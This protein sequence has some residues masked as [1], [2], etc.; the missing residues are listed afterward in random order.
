MRSIVKVERQYGKTGRWHEIGR[1]VFD[2]YGALPFKRPVSFV[3]RV[4]GGGYPRTR[5]HLWGPFL[6]LN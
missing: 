3:G 5:L 6:T 4:R 1:V 2:V